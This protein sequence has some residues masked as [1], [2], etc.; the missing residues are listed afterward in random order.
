MEYISVKIST[1]PSAQ[2]WL[3]QFLPSDRK[4]AEKL[5]DQLVYITTD[6]VMSA[7]GKSIDELINDFNSVAIFPVR[8]LIKDPTEQSYFDLDDDNVI[9][10]VQPSGIHLGSEA[11]VS[12]LITQLSRRNIEKVISLESSK[13]DPTINNLREKRVNSLI[14]VDDLIGSGNRTKKFLELIYKH[15]TIRSWMSG[16]KIEIHIVAYM[17]SE[18][19]ENLINNW[20]SKYRNSK[21]HVL[22]HCPMLDINHLDIINLC[23]RYADKKER[24]PIGFADN[25]VRVVFSHSAPNNL[26]A[27]LYRNKDKLKTK[28][29][30]LRG[31]VSL[32]VALFPRRALTENLKTELSEAKPISSINYLLKELLQ[33]VRQNPKASLASLN[34]YFS[35]T[36]AQLNLCKIRCISFG[37]LLEVSNTLAL[38]SDGEKEIAFLNNHN[39]LKI[40]DNNENNYYPTSMS[41]SM[42]HTD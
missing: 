8:E 25:P 9:P 40:I 2:N 35:G 29:A 37:W 32:W 14:L 23:T 11:F 24:F 30:A 38:T 39:K 22:N 10:I 7:L 20:C 15:P 18:K 42:S 4:T 33:I 41:R 26:P 31:K 12:N 6:D 3:E 5:L 28:D 1:I 13:K 36:T 17:A 27:I 21:L 34:K 19:G 16:K